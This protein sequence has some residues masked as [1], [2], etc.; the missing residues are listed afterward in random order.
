MNMGRNGLHRFEAKG[1]N[2]EG[3]LLGEIVPTGAVPTFAE[4]VE[5]LGH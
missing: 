1:L 2:H 5:Q 3:K 4:E